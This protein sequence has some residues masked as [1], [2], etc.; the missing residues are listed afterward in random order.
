MLDLNI[1]ILLLAKQTVKELTQSHQLVERAGLL[2]LLISVYS[3]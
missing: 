2:V 3:F 1:L